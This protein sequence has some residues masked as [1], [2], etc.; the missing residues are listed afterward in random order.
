MQFDFDEN[1][2]LVD[3]WSQDLKIGQHFFPPA[4]KR[5]PKPVK[6]FW[7]KVEEYFQTR[8]IWEKQNDW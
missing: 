2:A 7:Q 8:N 3:T 6:G 5:E 4:P 1:L